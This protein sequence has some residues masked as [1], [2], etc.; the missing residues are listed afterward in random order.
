LTEHPLWKDRQ[1]WK[2]SAP[3]WKRRGCG[4]GCMSHAMGYPAAIPDQ[5]NARLELKKD[6]TFRLYSGISDMG[7]GN[8]SAYARIAAAILDQDAA[9]IELLQPD[10]N[11]D[12]PSGSSSASR[13]TYTFGNA[14]IEAAV[15]LKETILRCAARSSGY[16]DINAVE[17]LPGRARVKESGRSIPLSDIAGL[18]ADDD[19][20]QK[21][22]FRAPHNDSTLP[23]LYLGAHVIFSYGAHLARI[24]V[25][26]LTGEIDVVDYVAVTDAGKVMNRCVYDQQVQGSIAQG[27]GYALMEDYLVSEGRQQ[28]GDLATY[29][30]PTSV[31]LP[32]M[33]SIAVEPEE[34]TGPYGMK[35]LGEVVISGCLPAIANA[36]HDACGVRITR[37][38]LTQERVLS[39]LAEREDER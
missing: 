15:V 32:D 20:S 16:D 36:F 4:I 14:V 28:T 3:K 13:T 2:A 6:G 31:D 38:P 8:S 1:A 10:T 17:L 19:R 23:V 35:G 9:A 33:I 25:D 34:K 37:S 29:I 27:I 24:E 30:V 7:Q 11:H 26:I 22:Y 5:A 12:L 39:A 18:I 21:G